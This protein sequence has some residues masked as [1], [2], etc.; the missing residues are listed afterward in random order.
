MTIWKF[1]IKTTDTQR[2]EMPV[3]TKLLDVQV[4]GD[5]PCLWG[6]VDPGAQKIARLIRVF[7]TGH[8]ING[9]P[10]EYVGTYQLLEGRLVF[11]V[12]SGPILADSAH[13]LRNGGEASD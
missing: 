3:G 11:H 4:Q 9:D 12:F 13:E 8:G 7:G 1:P 5:T 10:G 2:V 6:L